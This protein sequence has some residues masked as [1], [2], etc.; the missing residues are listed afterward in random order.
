MCWRGPAQGEGSWAR[1]LALGAGAVHAVLVPWER[2]SGFAVLSR[3]LPAGN[4]AR[5]GLARRQAAGA[6]A[7]QARGGLALVR[8]QCLVRFLFPVLPLAF[9]RAKG[10]F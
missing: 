1:D 4:G 5:R 2:P 7:G 3:K 10:C 6:S 9:P 8:R